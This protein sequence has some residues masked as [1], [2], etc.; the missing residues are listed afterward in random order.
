M[1][2]EL[3]IQPLT[4]EAFTPFG[5][6]IEAA[7]QPDMIINRGFCERYNDRAEIDF[8]SGQM[9]ISLFNAKPCTLPYKLDMMER[10]PLGSQAFIPM[11]YSA[12]LITV[13]QDENN[14]PTNPKAF[15]SRP[16]QAINF[17]RNT[18]HGIL[19]PLEDPGIFAVIDRIGSEKNLEEW[20]FEQ[21]YYVT[22]KST[23][24]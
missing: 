4:P 10:H 6:I 12:F 9:G 11:N 16:G 14:V 15:L 24:Q 19:T 13:A 17:H 7:G 18:W 21:I 22:H 8:L 20:F 5:D 1:K 23:E 3:Y 2:N